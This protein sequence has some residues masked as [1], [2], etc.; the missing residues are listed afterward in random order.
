MRI[1][2]TNAVPL[3]GGDEALLRAT[4]MAL[5]EKFP[6]ARIDVLCKDL[7][8]CRRYL[9]DVPLHPDWEYVRSP[10][11]AVRAK[12]ANRL[13]KTLGLRYVSPVLRPFYPTEER[14]VLQ[15]YE[16]ADLVISSAGGFLHDFYA[17]DARLEGFELAVSLGKRVVV[18]AQSVGPFWKARSVARVKE[19][20]GTL[21]RIYLRED[22]SLEHL[23]EA[24]I[25]S[26]RIEVTADAAFLLRRYYRDLFVAKS[27]A[28]RRIGMCFRNWD[29]PGGGMPR[30]REQ[31]VRLCRELLAAPGRQ[32]VFLST[33]Q[34]IPGYVD[35]SVLAKEIVGELPAALQQRCEIDDRRR[36]PAEL[37]RAY[38]GLDAFIGMRLHSAILSLL[39]GTPAMALGYEDKTRGIFTQMGLASYQVNADRPY[40]EWASCLEGFFRDL[41]SL[42]SRLPGILDAMAERSWKNVDVE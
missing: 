2:I 27:G 28:V 20:F 41:D 11:K 6:G 37:I 21:H 15:L 18:F 23:M 42:P 12:L 14:A 39:G 8:R 5:S 35:D 16:N 30:V 24:G 25:C 34:G 29:F 13:R 36:N 10:K 4:M 7:E 33:C 19:V 9:P 1:L 26:P 22:I 17:I 40:E 31:A 32:I 3:N 38:S